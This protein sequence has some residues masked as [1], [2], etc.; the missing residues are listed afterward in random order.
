M[1]S[2]L[3]QA[4]VAWPESTTEQPQLTNQWGMEPR[5]RVLS[6]ATSVP[7]AHLRGSIASA[8]HL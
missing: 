5:G 1:D 4:S 3:I 6:R 2:F 7:V 8:I